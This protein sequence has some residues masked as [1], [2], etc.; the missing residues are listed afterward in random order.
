LRGRQ[1]R[2]Q[3]EMRL[4]QAAESRRLPLTFE[5][6]YGHAMKQQPRVRLDAHSAVSLQDMRAMLQSGKP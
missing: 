1:W 5:V 6:I 4:A 3:L 2:A